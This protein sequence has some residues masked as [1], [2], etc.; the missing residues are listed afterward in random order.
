MIKTLC[1][2][3]LVAVAGA[4]AVVVVVEL[5]AILL[6]NKRKPRPHKAARAFASLPRQL[7]H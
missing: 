5:D 7:A 3:P 6:A 1:A 4:F 2:S